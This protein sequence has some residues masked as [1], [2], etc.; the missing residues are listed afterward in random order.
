MAHYT[1]DDSGRTDTECEEKP[2]DTGIVCDVGRAE[3]N[4]G[5]GYGNSWPEPLN[6][7]TLEESAEEQFFEQWRADATE[8]N[9]HG[10]SGGPQPRHGIERV[11]RIA[12]LL[13]DMDERDKHQRGKATG[14]DGPNEP[15]QKIE[16][17]KPKPEVTTDFAGAVAVAGDD[18]CA[19]ESRPK[20]RLRNRKQSQVAAW[21]SQQEERKNE[22]KRED[23][24]DHQSGDGECKG[25]ERGLPGA[26]GQAKVL[27]TVDGE[28]VAA[29]GT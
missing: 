18:A 5:H 2:S 16:P 24:S 22:E 8:Q 13:E 12:S 3:D 23:E 6:E 1:Q 25:T 29:I 15:D 27:L 28:H 20:A 7:L 4:G 17:A 11:I 14:H 9:E 10:P 21:V 19:E 26:V